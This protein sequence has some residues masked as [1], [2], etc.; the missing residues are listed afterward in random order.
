MKVCFDCS[1]EYYRRLLNNNEIMLGPH[2]TN[3][4]IGVLIRFRQEPIAIMADIKSMFY[5]VHVPENIKKIRIPFMG[6]QQS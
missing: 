5:Q 3:Q 2:L 6:K 1:T 4:T